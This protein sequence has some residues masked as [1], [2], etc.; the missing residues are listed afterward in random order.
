MQMRS[1]IDQQFELVKDAY[2]PFEVFEKEIKTY[3]PLR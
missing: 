3:A 1:S 2:L